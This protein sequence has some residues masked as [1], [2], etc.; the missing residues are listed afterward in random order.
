KGSV[1][2]GPDAYGLD[3]FAL[4]GVAIV[5]DTWWHAKNARQK[6]RVTWNDG[7]GVEQSSSRFAARA[8]ELSTQPAQQ[9]LHRHGDPDLAVHNAHTTVRANY[10]YPFLAHA[11]REPQNCTA[12]FDDG[13]LEL[14]T[15]T[16]LPDIG[17][18]LLAKTL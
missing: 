10:F 15:S 5:A 6:R 14:W 17:R 1:L 13:G 7:P 16:Q 8:S 18:P 3:G 4:D 2:G 12:R 9:T 11:S